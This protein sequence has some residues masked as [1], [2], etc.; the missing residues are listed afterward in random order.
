MSPASRVAGQG[1]SPIRRMAVG[2]PPGAINLALGEPGWQLPAVV[3]GVA[4]AGIT[5][6]VTLRL[7]IRR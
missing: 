6:Y 2:A 1:L 7:Y 4:M 3:I 5:A